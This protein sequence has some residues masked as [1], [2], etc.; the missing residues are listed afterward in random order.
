MDITWPGMLGKFDLL[1]L[2]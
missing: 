2:G 1:Y